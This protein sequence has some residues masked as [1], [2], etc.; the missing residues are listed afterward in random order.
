MA[1]MTANALSDPTIGI[2]T[3]K[4]RKFN[5]YRVGVYIIL[6]IVAVIYI[7]PFVWMVGKS[8][9]NSFEANNTTN[10]FPTMEVVPGNYN[11]VL[12]G[13]IDVGIN[14]RFIRYL[15][16]TVLLEVISVT[17]Q[18]VVCI[19]A[20]YAFARM[21]FPARDA[22]FGLLLLTIF[23]P[24]VIL[25]VPNLIIV[26]QI[27]KAMEPIGLKWIDNWPALVIPFLANTFSIFLLRQFFKQIPDELWDAARIDGCGHVLFLIRIVVPISG[28]AIMTTILFSFIAVW[29][30]LEWPILVTSSDAWRP[31]AVA[32]NDFRSEGGTKLQ[33]IMAASVIALLPIMI[34]YMFTQ[35]FFTQGI[36]T[37]GLK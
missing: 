26:T 9:Q 30:A 11:E 16:N 17:G 28:A 7:F 32:L 33:L 14:N 34:L 5:F 1:E 24:S 8:F 25:L 37:T 36:S 10:V 12:F 6:S 13:S 2:V 23:V 31:I 21:N 19:M 15:L 35:R 22:M 27:S 4:K 29:S 20:A 18:T 3:G